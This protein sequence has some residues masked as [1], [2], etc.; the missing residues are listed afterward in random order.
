VQYVASLFPPWPTNPFLSS[1]FSTP[2]LCVRRAFVAKLH[3]TYVVPT[4]HIHS[5]T[6]SLT[7]TQ[8]HTHTHS[9]G[10]R[11]IPH[12]NNS[13]GTSQHV[14]YS[15]F[16]NR[17]HCTQQRNK[18]PKKVRFLSAQLI[19]LVGWACGLVGLWACGLVGWLAGRAPF[20]S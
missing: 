14:L 19:G 2:L 17:K 20:Y 8:T 9:H 6:H 11:N 16:P 15:S 13:G 5:L 18:A 3:Q 1:P 4:P 10:Q 12:N 7:L